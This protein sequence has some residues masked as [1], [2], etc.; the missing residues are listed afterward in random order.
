MVTHDTG[1]HCVVNLFYTV[2]DIQSIPH[3]SEHI[4]C[5]FETSLRNVGFVLENS[6]CS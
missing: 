2:D 5:M 4:S 1:I 6:C 3:S